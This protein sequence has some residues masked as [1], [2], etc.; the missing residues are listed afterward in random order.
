MC[1]QTQGL[2]DYQWTLY[3]PLNSTMFCDTGPKP[4]SCDLG[5]LTPTIIIDMY[6]NISD[7][8]QAQCVGKCVQALVSDQLCKGQTKAQ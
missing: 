4:L 6:H 8:G 1:M 5:E 3:A 2:I 7:R